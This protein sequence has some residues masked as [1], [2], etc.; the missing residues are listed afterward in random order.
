MHHRP[1]AVPWQGL[2]RTQVCAFKR[3]SPMAFDGVAPQLGD[4]AFHQLLSLLPLDFSVVGASFPA[5]LNPSRI[6][7]K[8]SGL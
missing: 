6:L 8:T 1:K 7:P 4:C 3:L 2:P 5:F